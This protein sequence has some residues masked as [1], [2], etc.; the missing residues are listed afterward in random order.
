[1]IDPEELVDNLSR[2]MKTN[3]LESI[4]LGVNKL[5]TLS[6]KTWQKYCSSSQPLIQISDSVLN[7]V[8][9]ILNINQTFNDMA[10]GNK[11]IA[12]IYPQ[13]EELKAAFKSTI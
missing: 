6:P 13:L 3:N 7:D 9:I 2:S 4:Q 8:K 5:K 11:E 10:S 1:M 12:Q